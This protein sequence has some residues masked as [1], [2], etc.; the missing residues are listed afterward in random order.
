VKTTITLR[1]GVRI[2]AETG[3]AEL[4]AVMMNKTSGPS[5]PD[6]VRNPPDQTTTKERT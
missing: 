2:T 4:V 6:E 5:S 3:I 1:N